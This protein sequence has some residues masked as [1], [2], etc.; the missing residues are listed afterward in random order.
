MVISKQMLSKQFLSKV[1]FATLIISTLLGALALRAGGDQ[2]ENTRQEQS[3]LAD[4]PTD[5]IVDLHGFGALAQDEIEL[6]REQGEVDPRD[7]EIAKLKKDVETWKWLYNDQETLLVNQRLRGIFIAVLNVIGAG[8]LLGHA[9]SGPQGA[10]MGALGA[11]TGIGTLYGLELWIDAGWMHSHNE[12][13]LR[14]AAALLVGPQ[15]A[16]TAVATVGCMGQILA[17]EA[18]LAKKWAMDWLTKNCSSKGE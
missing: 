10:L 14:R 18:G 6:A 3:G 1:A 15:A 7:E 13:K 8:A 5:T 16:I 11:Y 17:W 9:H 12:K 2:E 4:T